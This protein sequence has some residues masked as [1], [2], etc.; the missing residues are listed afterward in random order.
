MRDEIDRAE[1][2]LGREGVLA[3]REEIDRG[4]Q[5]EDVRRGGDSLFSR[6][7]LGGLVGR[8]AQL[9]VR[10]GHQGGRHGL[11]DTEIDDPRSRFAQHD[12]GGFQ[13]AV[14]GVGRVDVLERLGDPEGDGEDVPARQRTGFRDEF[15]QGRTA[16]VLAGQPGFRSIRVRVDQVRDVTAADTSGDVDLPAETLGEL[17]VPAQFRLQELDRDRTA[18]GRD[19]QKDPAE[20]A[21]AE[22]RP[23]LVRTGVAGV[24]LLQWFEVER[25]HVGN[26]GPTAYEEELVGPAAVMQVR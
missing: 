19:G 9:G 20:A 25:G 15:E 18:I 10:T 5:R 4:A 21:G 6:G 11:G 13:I 2:V 26:G 24:A 1:R 23:E 8:R 3:D 14:H 12:V 22:A 17:R 16:D 7:L